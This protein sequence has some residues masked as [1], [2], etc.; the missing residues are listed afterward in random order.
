MRKLN[1]GYHYERPYFGSPSLY[2]SCAGEITWLCIKDKQKFNAE[3]N[4]IRQIHRGLSSYE[5]SSAQI[6][7]L[8]TDNTY[9]QHHPVLGTQCLSSQ[10]E[11][12]PPFEAALRM[13]KLQFFYQEQGEKIQQKIASLS[14]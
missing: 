2:F 1:D 7:S 10:K 4:R 6:K 9:E 12:K 14:I 5:F 3:L 8:V 11:G 13:K